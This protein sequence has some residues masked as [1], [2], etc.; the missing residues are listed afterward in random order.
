VFNVALELISL[1]ML[2]LDSSMQMKI[3]CYLI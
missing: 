2:M 3:N 1:M